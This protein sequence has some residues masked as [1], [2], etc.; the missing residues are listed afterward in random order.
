MQVKNRK[1]II[2]TLG[3]LSAIGPFSID[4]YLPA[5]P[6]MAVGLN[7][8]VPHVQLSLTSYFIGIALGQLFYGP[9]IDRFGRLVPLFGGLSIYLIASVICA[10]ASSVDSLILLRFFQALGACAGMVVARAMVRDIFPVS[11][12]A[13]IFSLLMLVSGISP[14]LAP[15]LGGYMSAGLGWRSIFFFLTALCVLTILVSYRFLFESKPAD[16]EMSLKPKNVLADF[17]TVLKEPQFIFYT[18][19][20]AMASAGMFAYISGSAYVFVE[21]FGVSEKQYGWLFGLNATG[22]ILASQLNG[23]MLRRTTSQEIIKT[24]SLVQ[25]IAAFTMFCLS[26]SGVLNIYSTLFV[27]FFYM[28][29]QGFLFPNSSALAMAP[30]SKRAGIASALL[31]SFQMMFSAVASFAVSF[32]HNNTAVPM[33]AIIL[34]CAS[35]SFILIRVGQHHMKNSSSLV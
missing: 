4:M 29:A 19:A 14:I 25:I 28:F 15:T 17:A 24:V 6:A 33:T 1:F 30:F 34:F 35:C 22:L 11:E 2:F 10:F 8:T 27:L 9:V 5:F 26:F 7:S 18:L 32:F 21:M 31:G 16:K 13:K 20:A 12:N 3:V 23:R